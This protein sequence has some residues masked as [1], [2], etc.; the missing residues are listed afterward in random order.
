MKH[1]IFPPVMYE[2]ICFPTDLPR[3]YAVRFIMFFSLIGE[4]RYLSVLICIQ[5]LGLQTGVIEILFICLEMILHILVN[6]L[7]LFSHMVNEF[8]V[9]TLFWFF[10]LLSAWSFFLD[11][12]QLFVYINKSFPNLSFIFWSFFNVLT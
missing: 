11:F 10:C 2:N 9:G 3:E 5:F 6:Y 4:K 7:C 12:W 1:F 8:L